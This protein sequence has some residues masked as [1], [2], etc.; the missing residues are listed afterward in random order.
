MDHVP[1]APLPV[2]RC[3]A[4]VILGDGGD[5]VGEALVECLGT[6]GI[7]FRI[8][9]PDNESDASALVRAD[10]VFSALPWRR[11]R[12]LAAHLPDTDAS[13][14]LVPCVTA[15]ARD[16]DGYHMEAV[17][18]GSVVQLLADLLPT[19]RVVGALQHITGEQLSAAASGVFVTDVPV[20]GDDREATDLVEGIIDLVPG[21]DA[22][23]LG[24]LRTSPAVEGLAAVVRE[25]ATH[26]RG[27]G[28]FRVGGAPDHSLRFI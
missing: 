4:V 14:V 28:G 6:T 2:P 17:P 3:A 11:L 5:P 25:V 24:G 10:V 23:Y 16:D 18:G 13:H 8:V 12:D 9:R 21:L 27:T 1:V 20:T 26:H 22:V 15:L 7:G 19:W